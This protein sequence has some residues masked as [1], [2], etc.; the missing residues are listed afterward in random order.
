MENTICCSVCNEVLPAF[1]LEDVNWVKAGQP[2]CS[3]ECY[4]ALPEEPI[5]VQMELQF[6]GALA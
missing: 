1:K 5:Y 3:E 2:A 4:D 6:Q